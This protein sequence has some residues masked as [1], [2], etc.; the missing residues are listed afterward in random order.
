MMG[1]GTRGRVWSPGGPA[2]FQD[3][4]HHTCL[5]FPHRG[6]P[7]AW[8]WCRV[9]KPGT[10]P[11]RIH[12][13]SQALQRYKHR[14]EPER[15]RGPHVS[16]CFPPG[17]LGLG[18]R[19]PD[20]GTGEAQA[21]PRVATPPSRKD[22]PGLLSTR[23]PFPP[24]H[25]CSFSVERLAELG[26]G[27]DTLGSGQN[28][29]SS[30]LASSQRWAGL[31]GVM[32]STALCFPNTEWAGERCP[33]PALGPAEWTRGSEGGAPQAAAREP[34]PGLSSGAGP[35]RE[36]ATSSP[37]APSG[38]AGE[39]GCQT[40]PAASR[41]RCGTCK[42]PEPPPQPRRARPPRRWREWPGRG[43]CG[44]W[45]WPGG[46]PP[47]RWPCW[48]RERDVLMRGGIPMPSQA[49]PAH[50]AP[51][52][53][54]HMLLPRPAGEEGGQRPGPGPHGS[55]PLGEVEGGDAQRPEAA[56]HGEDGEAQVVPGR[57]REEVVFALALRRGC[58]TLQNT[59]RVCD[60]APDCP[61]AS[62]WLF[63][64]PMGLSRSGSV[65]STKK[66]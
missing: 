27:R 61:V 38:R 59:G 39:S 37:A 9:Y 44:R 36:S 15:A 10:P 47:W 11:S 53:L 24:C 30:K 40:P 20:N 50:Q 31:V 52:P 19:R 58:V 62:M 28:G 57:Q 63:A 4:C 12:G 66:P 18:I 1:A 29:L 5:L 56:E 6:T 35:S 60:Q 7:G 54:L 43:P 34:P 46:S 51:G 23:H 2:I 16:V 48:S 8:S 49:A 33:G 42:R 64:L 32:G 22:W 21:V 25:S 55:Y 3:P 65:L 17:W 45:C 14:P 41:G 26:E 13:V